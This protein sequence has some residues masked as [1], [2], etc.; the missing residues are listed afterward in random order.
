MTPRPAR[1]P[2]L[3]MA[4]AMENLPTSFRAKTGDERPR[5]ATQIPAPIE[6]TDSL[7]PVIFSLIL[8]NPF[9]EAVFCTRC[10]SPSTS[11]RIGICGNES[12]VEDC[13]STVEAPHAHRV[14]RPRSA[15]SL[16]LCAHPRKR[17]AVA[18]RLCDFTPARSKPKSLL[19]VLDAANWIW[20]ARP[21]V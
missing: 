10:G 7:R 6:I 4:A 16:Q 14:T 9:V 3:E 15:P 13:L 21:R 1:A 5:L 20:Y 2:W 8:S 19:G 12:N 18:L 17:L 11:V